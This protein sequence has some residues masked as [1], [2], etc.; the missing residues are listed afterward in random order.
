MVKFA[1][2]RDTSIP[3]M[4]RPDGLSGA[5]MPQLVVN[6]SCGIHHELA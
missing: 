3:C 1:L 4:A 2:A 5:A 6:E